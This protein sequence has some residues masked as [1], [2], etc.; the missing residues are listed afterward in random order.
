M[1]IDDNKAKADMFKQYQK[2]SGEL[3]NNNQN[4]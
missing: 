1:Q 4:I 2:T 3:I